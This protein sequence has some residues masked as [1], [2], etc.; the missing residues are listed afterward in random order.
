M[1]PKLLALWERWAQY[2]YEYGDLEAAQKLE[3]HMAEVYPSGRCH[4]PSIRGTQL[5]LSQTRLSNVLP[6]VTYT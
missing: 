5:T 2:E 3:K 1:I 4:S 6:N